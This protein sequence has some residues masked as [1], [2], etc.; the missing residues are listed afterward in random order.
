[1]ATISIAEVLCG[2]FERAWQ[3]FRDALSP[4]DNE[5]FSSADIEWLVPR[6]LAYHILETADFYS[7]DCNPD[8]FAWGH[9]IAKNKDQILDYAQQVEAKVKQWL[10]KHRD[11]Q[12]LE[13][14]SILTGTG[15]TV[16]D[17]SLYLLR[18]TQ[19]HLGQINSELRRRGLPRG[20]WR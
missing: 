4:L 10:L 2:Q 5:Q 1:M 19:H 11:P 17:R 9:F 3:T 12:F 15:A 7:S 16:L 14:Q 20:Q 13:R 8:G 6:N 18:H